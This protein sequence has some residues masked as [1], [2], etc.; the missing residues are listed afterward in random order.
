MSLVYADNEAPYRGPVVPYARQNATKHWVT[1]YSNFK[2]LRFILTNSKDF[3]ERA[4]AN[5]EVQIADRK[6]RYWMNHPNFDR[7][8]AEKEKAALDRQWA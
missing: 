5:K 7:S 3:E 1:H 4:R 6:M 8:I 2:Y